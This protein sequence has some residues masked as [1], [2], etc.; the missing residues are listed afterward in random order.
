[1]R[2]PFVLAA[3][4]GLLLAGCV[5][6]RALKP[7]LDQHRDVIQR[8]AGAHVRDIAL[9][10]AHVDAA[11]EQR[12]TLLMGNIH[13]ELLRRGYI[14][15]TGEPDTSAFDRDL[16]DASVN[17]TLTHDVRIGRLSAEDAHAWLGDYA[18]AIRMSTDDDAR[19]VLLARLS[20][21]ETLDHD[22]EALHTALQAHARD[23]A[24]LWSELDADTSAMER[25]ATFEP[26][27]TGAARQSLAELWRTFITSTT[28]DSGLIDA[29]I[30][31][32]DTLLPADVVAR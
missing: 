19:N 28:S 8:L 9:L 26:S 6:P 25:F 20:A 12:R 11:I 2:Y 27:P 5:Q 23:V 4:A 29:A 7:T 17:S 32:F 31:L 16:S 24:T 21:I 22:A 1:M 15:P 13:R 10:S 14:S 3:S 30:R 18:L